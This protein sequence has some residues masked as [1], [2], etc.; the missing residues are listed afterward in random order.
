[1]DNKTT[2]QLDKIE[3]TISEIQ[4]LMRDINTQVSEMADMLADVREKD[5]KPKSNPQY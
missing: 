1:M 2:E 4:E 5:N 3:T